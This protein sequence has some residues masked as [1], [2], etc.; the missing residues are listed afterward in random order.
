MKY[1]FLFILLFNIACGSNSEYQNSMELDIESIK[2]LENISLTA[3]P[4][5]IATMS[6]GEIVSV[7]EKGQMVIYSKEGDQ[8]KDIDK[9]GE[10]E[11]EL[12]NPTLVR[13]FQ[14]GFLVWCRDLLKMVAFDSE[15]NPIEEFFGF[16]HS[17]KKFVVK[18]NLI[19]TYINT[20]VDK[21]FIQIYDM[22]EGRIIK[23]IGKTVNEQL[24]SNLNSC[25][26]GLTLYNDR[27]VF[28]SSNSLNLYV[29]DVDEFNIKEVEVLDIDF[30]ELKVIEDAENLINSNQRKAI[31]M[32]LASAVVTRLFQVGSDL[33][34]LGEVG[35]ITISNSALNSK[36]RK[37]FIWKL[38]KEFNVVGKYYYELDPSISCKLITS[39]EDLLNRIIQ[40]Q[41]EEEMDY[42]V[43]KIQFTKISEID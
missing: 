41:G 20:L 4:V 17:I 43:E 6:N 13:S 9:K 40:K 15:G 22:R 36:N 26:G 2:L 3:A 16:N 18:E 12:K 8:M 19:F 25:G 11:L 39:G 35:E 31:E 42:F 7:T 32:S 28:A 33:I 14:E 37:S 5:S 24:I 10:G 38:D 30:N 21:P 1:F 27:I 23:E 34:I 29:V